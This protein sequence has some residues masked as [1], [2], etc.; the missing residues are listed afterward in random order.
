M[1][2][3]RRTTQSS[4]STGR[5]AQQAL[6][7]YAQEL[8]RYLQKRVNRPQDV[9][10]LAQEV[11]LRLLRWEDAKVVEKPLQYLYGVAAHVIADFRV[12]S[13]RL[14]AVPFSDAE[15]SELMECPTTDGNDSVQESLDIE[16]R[17]TEALGQLPDT[18]AAIVIGFHREGLTYDEIGNRLNL[19]PNTVH[20]YLTRARAQLRMLLAEDE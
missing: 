19:S 1:A 6:Q 7:H 2:K 4:A 12:A 18:Y 15:F 9:D 11:Y 16:R 13:S 17:L 3:A 10:D 14:P 5:L 20:K 8:R